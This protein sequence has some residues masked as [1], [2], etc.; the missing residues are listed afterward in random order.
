MMTSRKIICRIF[1]FFCL[2]KIYPLLNSDDRSQITL[3]GSSS[4]AVLFRDW[5]FSF[6]KINPSIK[7]N[8]QP[9][10]STSAQRQ[11][12]LNLAHM[13]SSDTPA[14][15]EIQKKAKKKFLSFLHI[16]I[17][18]S[19]IVIVYNLKTLTPIR[20]SSKIIASI[21]LGKTTRWDDP[22][23]IKENPNIEK[24][25]LN[26]PITV[27]SRSDA[28]GST[29]ILTEFLEKTTPIWREKIGKTTYSSWDP[30]NA[31][32]IK[33]GS[34]V[35]AL[36]KKNTGSFGYIPLELA[37]KINLPIATIQNQSGNWIIPDKKSCL[38]SI[39]Q[40][41]NSLH[42][43]TDSLSNSRDPLGY[44]ILGFNWII[45]PEKFSDDLKK[46]Q[47]KGILSLIHWLLS[48][49]AKTIALEKGFFP[50]PD[51]KIFK[52]LVS[53][54]LDKIQFCGKKLMHHDGTM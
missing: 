16:P 31:F 29:E 35:A 19:P 8:Y 46:D 7:I 13:S 12:L 38:R 27:I 33:G 53:Q 25:I 4:S 28:S 54:E 10:G 2:F 40:F 50:I 34:A 45:V 1:I 51:H 47:I 52:I 30:P 42:S 36:I 11:L 37:K 5:I 20:L 22:S 14:S 17:G 32:R 39:L 3:G 23:I 21:L 18:I 48:P 15:K 41:A 9:T 24:N 43:T 44:P 49:M 6:E 26:I